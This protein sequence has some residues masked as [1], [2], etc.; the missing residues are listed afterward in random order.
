M[1]H[2]DEP[3]KAQLE[4]RM[5]AILAADV[6]G[7][8]R[9]M[10]ADEAGTIARVT[11]ARLEVIEPLLS[12]H[13]GRLVKLMGDGALAVFESVVDAVACAAAVQR[14]MVSWNA[15]R[16]D[17]EHLVLRIGVNLGDV[18]LLD[19]DV[20]G[21]GVNV[22][23]RLEQLCEPGGIMVSGTAFDH[24]QGKLGFPLE[25]AGNQ[26]VKNISRP[27]RA[28]RARLDGPPGPT[29]WRAPRLPLRALAAALVLLAAG[30]GWWLW[31]S[32]S[33][34]SDSAS[35]AVLPFDNLGGDEAT[36][37]LADGISE[38]IVTELTRFST[39]D[40]I[41][42]D[43]TR[44]YRGKP[45]DIREIGRTLGVLYVLDGTVQ[46]QG[47]RV[48]VTAQLIDTANARDVW[49]DRWDRPTEDIFEVQSELAEAVA[50]K[51]ASP[52]S[53]EIAAADRD[54]AKRKPPKS[55][56]A[57][58][59]Y[60]L[61][62]EA[63]QRGTREGLEKA[64]E[65]LQRS[66]AVDPGFARAWTGLSLTYG[67][68]AEAAG[69]P[70]RLQE[71]REAAARKAVEF[72]PSDAEAHAALAAFY[73]DTGDA[74]RAEAE[75][76]RAL[77]LNPGSADLLAIYAGWASDFGEPEQG[78]E[79]AERAMRLNPATPAWAVYNFGYAFFM[80]GRYDDALRML[81]RLPKDAY[82]PAAYV[83]RAAALGA[84]GRTEEAKKAVAE[85]LAHNP[86]LSIESFASG[87][88]SNDAQRQRLTET[89]R[90]AGFPV[91]AGEA[92]LKA[93]PDLR[94]L[95]ECVTS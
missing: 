8:S 52:Y 66:L 53:G 31:S 68:L 3:G 1:T 93:D 83:Y 36:A 48:R 72:D 63:R 90:L 22:A 23:A 27:V 33:A 70:P 43:S 80:V 34:P 19:G 57:Y 76:D 50:S 44:V 35:I 78:A 71:E 28:Y 24:L 46:R 32:R 92:D 47:D 39:L 85:A 61:G 14:G 13:R 87:Y 18:A 10:E 21:D 12:Q 91:C 7:Y 54:A 67:D 94:R 59:L 49:A 26:K 95:P 58:D 65:L 69:Y 40:V 25:F 84:L 5:L 75:F 64:I 37:R 29:K 56:S 4:R 41:A 6:V 30:G 16:T 15:G 45:V 79:A 17:G 73:M 60:L 38:D 42:R 81:N 51:V 2:A 88:G 20:Y 89:M 62:I 74:A 77:A 82:T 55:L 9:Q 86:G 11:A